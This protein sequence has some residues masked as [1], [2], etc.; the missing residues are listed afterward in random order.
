MMKQFMI[1]LSKLPAVS[2]INGGVTLDYS[3]G[4]YAGLTLKV[5]PGQKILSR[6]LNGNTLEKRDFKVEMY[7]L[8][9][10]D[11]MESAENHEILEQL[12]HEICNTKPPFISEDINIIEIMIADGGTVIKSAIGEGLLTFRFSVIYKR[13]GGNKIDG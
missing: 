11:S 1:W 7:C 8:F 6:Y 2:K 9:S 4:A 10:G 3:G 12:Q 5:E 13:Q